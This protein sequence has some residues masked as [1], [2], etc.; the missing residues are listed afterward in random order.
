MKPSTEA[1]TKFAE[2][3]RILMFLSY[4]LTDAETRYGNSDRG[5]LAL[6]RCLTEIKW[7]VINSPY[8]I[9]IYLNHCALQEIFTKVTAKKLGSSPG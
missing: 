4:R 7:L 5:C 2:N 8:K 1:A 9:F 3:E 6:V